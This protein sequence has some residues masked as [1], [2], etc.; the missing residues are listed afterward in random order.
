MSYLW[1]IE[2]DTY[3]IISEQRSF[4][5]LK[6]KQRGASREGNLEK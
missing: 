2:P 6:F 4:E 5:N 3:Q 1:K